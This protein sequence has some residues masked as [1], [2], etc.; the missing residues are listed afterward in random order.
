MG[1]AG[2]DEIAT[3]LGTYAPLALAALRA[4]APSELQDELVIGGTAGP[5]DTLLRERAQF[6]VAA[7]DEFTPYAV[8]V[9]ERAKQSLDH[10]RRARFVAEILTVVCSAGTLG[11][12]GLKNEATWLMSVL[13]LIAAVATVTAEH[14]IRLN[15]AGNTSLVDLY[16]KLTNQMY[17][18]RL[19][20]ERLRAFLHRDSVLEDTKEL[21]TLISRANEICGLISVLRHELLKKAEVTLTKA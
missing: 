18:L 2:V 14:L 10:A 3:L 4:D 7:I 9:L 12:L 8:F 1:R 16:T 20:G 21:E 15:L 17:E 5:V 19:T 11:T 13:S 6:A